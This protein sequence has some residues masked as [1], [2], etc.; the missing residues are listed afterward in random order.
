MASLY[1]SFYICKTLIY[2]TITGIQTQ[3]LNVNGFYE[4]YVLSVGPINWLFCMER[5][6][7]GQALSTAIQK[8]AEPVI[9]STH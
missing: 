9:F 5:G 1:L 8:P 7:K 6:G 2:N 4:T 3:K